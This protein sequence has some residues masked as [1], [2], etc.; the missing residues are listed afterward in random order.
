MVDDELVLFPQLLHHVRG[1][2]PSELPHGPQRSVVHDELPRQPL[3][4]VEAGAVP[5]L[6]V[7]HRLRH[8]VSMTARTETGE[9]FVRLVYSLISL[10]RISRVRVMKFDF[11]QIRDTKL[12]HDCDNI[13]DFLPLLCPNILGRMNV[14]S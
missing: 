12:V 14:S 3:L 8:P 7:D 5:H 6:Q 11:S 10:C 1:H 9:V 13:E 4:H 2:E